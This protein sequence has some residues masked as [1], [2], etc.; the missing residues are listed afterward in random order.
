MLN[1][2]VVGR[3]GE[4]MGCL[5]MMGVWMSSKF[6]FGDCDLDFRSSA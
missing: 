5:R 3:K 4:G 6:Q 2:M 1:M